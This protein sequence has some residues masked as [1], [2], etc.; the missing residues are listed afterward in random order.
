MNPVMSVLKEIQSSEQLDIN[1]LKQASRIFRAINHPLR[2]SIIRL[3]EEFRRL[4]VTQI[5]FKL[6]VEQSVA[7]QHLAILREADILSAEREG[8]NIYYSLNESRLK[9]ISR[10]I[11]TLKD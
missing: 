9:A 6:R 8:K 10:C 4:T 7:S 5:Y 1:D 3:V 2:L 11:E